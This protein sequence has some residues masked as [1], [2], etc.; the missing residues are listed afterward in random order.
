MFLNDNGMVHGVDFNFNGWGSKVY[1]AP[2]AKLARSLLFD[3]NIPRVQSC[4]AAEGGA[5]EVDGE[6][7]LIAG[8][9]SILNDSRNPEKSS[10][11]IETELTLTLGIEKFILGTRCQRM[12]RH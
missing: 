1:G 8:E 7:T 5:I 4:I 10:Q 2:N 12:L 11:Q 9:S 3:I 6:G